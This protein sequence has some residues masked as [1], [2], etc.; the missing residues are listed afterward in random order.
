L[1]IEN[2]KRL[3]GALNGAPII[4]MF[5]TGKDSIVV[6]DLIKRFHKGPVEYVF[7]YFV[8]GLEIK[9]KLIRYYE[10]KWDIKIT[11]RPNPASFTMT[12]G[13]KIT[14][15][16]IVNG[17]RKELNISWTAWGILRSDSLQR[18]AIV[19]KTKSKDSGIDGIDERNKKIYPVGWWSKKDINSYLKHYKL[20]VPIEY[21]L[22]FN[23][24]ISSPDAM[25]MLYLKNNHRKDYEKIIEKFP[26]CE[27]MVWKV[28]NGC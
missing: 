21:E 6:G 2:A 4:V 22:G 26:I 10:N 11:Q 17:L 27:Q 8:P 3:I 23:H 25:A 20:P 19:G 15:S 28:E 14:Q 9:E 1:L 24:D 16:D 18:M 12:T 13:K 5:S 7:L